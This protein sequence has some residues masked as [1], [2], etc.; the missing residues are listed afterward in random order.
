VRLNVLFQRLQSL[1]CA[2]GRLSLITRTGH[3][4]LWG[5]CSTSVDFM[6]ATFMF[7]TSHVMLGIAVSV[8]QMSAG[9]WSRLWLQS[10]RH[11]HV[12]PWIKT[13]LDDWQSAGLSHVASSVTF[14]ARFKSLLKARVRLRLWCSVTFYF[15]RDLHKTLNHETEIFHLPDSDIFETFKISNCRKQLT[16]ASY[17]SYS[18]ANEYVSVVVVF[19]G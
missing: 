2:A 12:V 15:S 16:E 13:H 17:H 19:I 14:G 11:S 5:S 7:K 1:Q 8:G 10:P 3:R 9:V 6:L 18:T 4:E